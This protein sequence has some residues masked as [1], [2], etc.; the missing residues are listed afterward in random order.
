MRLIFHSGNISKSIILEFSCV[1]VYIYHSPLRQCYNCGRLGD[2]SKGCR[3][4]KR[5]LKCSNQGCVGNCVKKCLL[6]GAISHSSLDRKMCPK[7]KEEDDIL[8][9]MTIKRLSKTE[10]LKSYSTNRFNI[11]K[12]YERNFPFLSLAKSEKILS[13]FFSFMGNVFFQR[14]VSFSS[15]AFK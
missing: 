1:R 5:C 14:W 8:K 9:I 10:V 4:N 3:S 7:W 2:T 15:L 13:E 11:F 6:C 12:G